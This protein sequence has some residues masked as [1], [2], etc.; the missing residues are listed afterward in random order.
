VRRAG[1]AG[2]GLAGVPL[3]VTTNP[4]AS[5]WPGMIHLSPAERSSEGGMLFRLVR[6]RASGFRINYFEKW[7]VLTRCRG[8]SVESYSPSPSP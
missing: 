5:G 4:M 7:S 8:T 3:P 6:A 1:S 2:A